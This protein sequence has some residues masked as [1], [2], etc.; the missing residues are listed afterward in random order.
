MIAP[1]CALESQTVRDEGKNAWAVTSFSPLDPPPL[2]LLF[3]RM[4]KLLENRESCEKNLKK[5]KNVKLLVTGFWLCSGKKDALFRRSARSRSASLN[6]II[7]FSFDLEPWEPEKNPLAWNQTGEQYQSGG[8]FVESE[9]CMQPVAVERL[10]QGQK[11]NVDDGTAKGAE[12][13][14]DSP[15]ETTAF[16]ELFY[17]PRILALQVKREYRLAA[18]TRLLQRPSLSCYHRQKN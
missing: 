2:S 13:T 8:R 3:L 5:S 11:K 4:R 17:S 12:C 9:W 6:F 16:S 7:N 1:P 14:G 15:N 10:R 18:P